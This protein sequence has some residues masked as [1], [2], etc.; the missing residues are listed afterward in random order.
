MAKNL[1]TSQ[2]MRIKSSYRLLGLNVSSFTWSLISMSGILNGRTAPPP[3][4]LSDYH[5][6][7]LPSW[8]AMYSRVF[9]VWSGGRYSSAFEIISCLTEPNRLVSTST[10]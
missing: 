4:F 10:S 9:A 7:S 1:Y 3:S 6:Y 2:F 5:S 8:S